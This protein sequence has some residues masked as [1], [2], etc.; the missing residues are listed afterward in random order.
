MVVRRSVLL[1]IVGLVVALAACAGRSVP[2]TE[3][4]GPGS[5]APLSD[6]LTAHRVEVSGTNGLVTAGHPLASMAGIRMLMQ[7]GTAADAAVA[8]LAT[9]NAVEPMNSGAG[10]NGFTTIYDKASDKV[11]SLNATGAAPR[12]LDASGLTAAELARG[13]KSGVTPGLFGGWIALLDRFGTMRLGQVL[14][15]AIEYAEHGHVLDSYVA[16][17]IAFYRE[18]FEA[19]D[20][21]AAVYL[22]GGVAPRRGNS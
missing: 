20:T 4:E 11:Y 5:A 13:F 15:P 6:G 17:S 19:F 22:P 18:M 1:T 8:I 14:E 10:G 12:A 7:G 16:N 9:L 21:T 3:T 2:P